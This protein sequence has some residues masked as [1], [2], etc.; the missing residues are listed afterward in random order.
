MSIW[1]K[2]VATDDIYDRC[3]QIGY[4]AGQNVGFIDG[5]VDTMKKAR[6]VAN[7]MPIE[8]RDVVY[9]FLGRLW[10]E[11]GKEGRRE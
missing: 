10:D 6:K 5:R 9:D 11:L 4:E 2:E 1:H 3:R 8:T 7:E